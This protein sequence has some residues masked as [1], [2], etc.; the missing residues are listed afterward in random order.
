MDFHYTVPTSKT[1]MDTISSLE[2]NL[3]SNKFGVLWHLDLTA[4]L[5]EKG[6]DSYT[7][8]FHILEV[9]N[10]VEAARVLN[11]NPI[12]GYFLPCKIAVYEEGG[13][14]LIGLPKP[15]AMVG[16]LENEELK[17]IAAEIEKTL[18]RVLDQS[19]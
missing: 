14:T 5:E 9:C 11:V 1:I 13:K 6:V 8:P 17:T 4:K 7:S 19:K 18:I 12:V 15:T 16:M 2:K 3:Q 10:P